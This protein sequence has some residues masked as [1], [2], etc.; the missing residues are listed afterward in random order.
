MDWPPY[1][2]QDTLL[3]AK[4]GGRKDRLL[5]AKATME[6]YDLAQ[7]HFMR[8]E[9]SQAADVL[10]NART[11]RQL[12]KPERLLLGISLARS[13]RN[14]EATEVLKGLLEAYPDT[15]EALSWM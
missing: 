1:L 11:R 6:A 5:L 4:E 3:R 14:L 10:L 9:F 15:F 12:D 7:D 8:G 2:R 13:R